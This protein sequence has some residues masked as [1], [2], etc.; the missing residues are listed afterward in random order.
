MFSHGRSLATLAL[1]YGVLMVPVIGPPIV[2]LAA[3]GLMLGGTRRGGDRSPA[4]LE[5]RKA[6]TAKWIAQQERR[7]GK[8]K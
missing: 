8:R 1:F 4:T 7:K 5:D 2:A 3:I 6:N